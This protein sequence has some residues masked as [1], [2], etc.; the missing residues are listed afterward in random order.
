VHP[1][2]KKL[3]QQKQ[4]WL[5][6]VT[7][8]KTLHTQNNFLTVDLLKTTWMSVR[9][10]IGRDAIERSKQIML[11]GMQSRGRNKLFAGLTSWPEE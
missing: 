1:V 3:P 8:W 5:N 6:H 4:K 11:D 9:K 7:V 2:E 10:T